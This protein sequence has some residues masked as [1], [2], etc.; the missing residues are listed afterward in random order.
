MTYSGCDVSGTIKYYEMKLG[1]YRKKRI[2]LQNKN[3]QSFV[4]NSNNSEENKSLQTSFHRF[5]SR[6][7]FSFT[8]LTLSPVMQTSHL[9]RL[10]I[11]A[12]LAVGTAFA[13]AVAVQTSLV[14]ALDYVVHQTSI[15][16]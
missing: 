2:P 9:I 4:S 6:Y 1:V 5:P 10:K 16:R 8:S 11:P 7:S 3:T 12:G 15:T 13:A 14:H